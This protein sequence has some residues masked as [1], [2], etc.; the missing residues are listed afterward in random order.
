M[1]YSIAGLNN[2]SREIHWNT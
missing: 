1:I 2:F